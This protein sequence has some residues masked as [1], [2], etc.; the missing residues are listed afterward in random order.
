MELFLDQDNY[1]L[2]KLSKKA[3]V[4]VVVHDPELA[5]LPDEY[6]LDLQPNT[7]SSISIRKVRHRQGSQM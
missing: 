3:G 6:G 1:M 5:P 2:K 7:A 4:R